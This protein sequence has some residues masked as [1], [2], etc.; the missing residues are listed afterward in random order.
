MEKR[1]LLMAVFPRIQLT[2]ASLELD[3]DRAAVVGLIT[4]VPAANRA[5]ALLT[6]CIL[7]ESASQSPYRG[8]ELR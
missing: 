7:L 1:K 6:S 5:S 4:S 3:T 2:D 8:V